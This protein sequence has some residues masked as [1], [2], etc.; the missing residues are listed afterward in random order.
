MELH[1]VSILAAVG[2]LAFLGMAIR[3]RQAHLLEEACAGRRGKVEQAFALASQVD[4]PTPRTHLVGVWTPAE[5]EAFGINDTDR[6]IAETERE[7]NPPVRATAD[8]GIISIH[9]WA[10]EVP[11]R[12]F[13]AN[14]D[15]TYQEVTT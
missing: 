11:V 2:M 7:L 10:S 13:V 4:R 8:G 12:T 6:F 5:R 1:L 15:A 14:T 9:A 3:E